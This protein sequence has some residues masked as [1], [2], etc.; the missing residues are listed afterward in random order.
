M[1]LKGIGFLEFH[2]V[3]C[4]QI[5]NTIRRGAA[6]VLEYRL[7]IPWLAYF[8]FSTEIGYANWAK[9]NRPH[10]IPN[11]LLEYQSSANDFKRQ[12]L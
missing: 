11:A 10:S 5:Q 12:T 6:E 2:F 1:D 9:Q 4:S 7:E 8:P 3:N